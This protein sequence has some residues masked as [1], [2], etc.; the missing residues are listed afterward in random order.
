[1]SLPQMAQTHESGLPAI[2]LYDRWLLL[3]T[4]AIIGL[5]LLMVAS[6]SIVISEKVF[7]T[8]FHFLI[9]QCVFL[10]LG[11]GIASVSFRISMEFWESQSFHLLLLSF[12]LLILVLVPGLG[13]EV[14]GSMRWLGVGILGIQVSE[15]VKIAIIIYL[16]GYLVRHEKEVCTRVRGFLKPLFLIGAVALL[17]LR[18]PDFGAA[19]VIL[20]TSLGMLFLAGVRLWQFAALF[21]SVLSL[22]IS[23]AISSP[24]RMERITTFLNPWATQYAGGYQLVQSL[25]AFGRGG[26]FGVGLGDSVQKLFY[27]PEAHTDFLFAVLTEELGLIGSLVVISLF[28][29]IVIRALKIGRQAYE[30]KKFFAA[31]LAYGLGLQLA[32]QVLINIGVNAGMLPTKGLTLPFMS[33]GGSS[34][35]MMCSV[36][37]ILLRIDHE[38]RLARYGMRLGR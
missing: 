5:G 21:G 23:I 13:R 7:Q 11:I 9:R 37:A 22:F 36:I 19:S 25:I 29:V 18:E 20:A 14:N 8:P 26:W 38:S 3:A 6:T 17:L 2:R 33:Y 12:A 32:M 28:G 10:I 1:M 16:A 4:A 15:F 34:L 31:F 27:L 30:E 35:L 24:Y